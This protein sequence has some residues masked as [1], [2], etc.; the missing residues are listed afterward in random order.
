MSQRVRLLPLLLLT[1]VWMLLWG[2]LTWLTA[3]SGVLVAVL[4]SVLFPMPRVATGVR[5]RPWSLL[6]LLAVFLRDLVL[7]SA[8]VAWLAVRPRPISPGTTIEVQLGLTDDLA[9]TVVAEVA[10]LVPGT[11]V[12]DVDD[13]TGIMTMHVLDAT[14]AESLERERRAVAALEARVG[15]ALGRGAP[16][17][18]AAS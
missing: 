4:I 15:R 16:I 10:S 12:V 18:E 14:D 17:R 6:V 8:R 2:R 7:A 13:A 11:V 9:R 1:P 3:V 5:V